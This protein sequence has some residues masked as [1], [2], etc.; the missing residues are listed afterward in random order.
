MHRALLAKVNRRWQLYTLAGPRAD[1]RTGAG[2]P[3]ELLRGRCL[4]ALGR[5]ALPTEGPE[6]ENP[7]RRQAG[8]RQSARNAVVCIRV[9]AAGWAVV[10]RCVGVDAEQLRALPWLPPAG[11]RFGEYNG[12][13]MVNQMVLRGGSWRHADRPHPLPL[14]QFLFYP[15][16][17]GN[18][19][20]FAWR[21][22]DE[23]ASRSASMSGARLAGDVRRGGVAG[24]GPAPQ[25]A[26]RPK[27]F[28]DERGSRL[29]DTICELGRPEYYLTRHRDGD[30]GILCRR[31]WRSGGERREEIEELGCTAL[32]SSAG[33]ASRKIRLLARN[34]CDRATTLASTFARVA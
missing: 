34:L 29:F 32:S 31:S 25:A 23:R 20:A 19:P 17:A 24:A 13:F 5:G 21:K 14:S 3:R 16:T 6:W 9:P 22:T 12:K 30:S 7:S 27:Y 1:E 15:W 10:R 8:Q 26:L 2:V 33:G 28:Y 18:S 11:R 4:R